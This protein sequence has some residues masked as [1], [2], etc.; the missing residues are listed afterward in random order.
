MDHRVALPGGLDDL[1]ELLPGGQQVSGLPE[2]QFQHQRP[3]RLLEAAHLVGGRRPGRVG[4][5]YRVQ[6]ADPAEGVALVL[7]GMAETVQGDD[8]VAGAARPAAQGHL[9]GHGPGREE[10]GGLRAEQGGGPLLQGLDDAVAVHVGGLVE[11]VQLLGPVEQGDA[12]A[13]GRDEAGAGEYAPRAAEGGHAPL[14]AAPVALLRRLVLGRRR[15]RSGRCRPLFLFCRVAHAGIMS[16]GPCAG[17]PVSAH[18][19][20]RARGVCSGAARKPTACGQRD[21]ARTDRVNMT[22]NR[23]VPRADWNGKAAVA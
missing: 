4:Q 9:L 8:R 14:P 15:F 7:L 19:P 20:T 23:P 17:H 16:R 6:A 2:R 5:P 22:R 21:A 3:E 1:G 11:V 13:Q 12:L 18:V 10:G